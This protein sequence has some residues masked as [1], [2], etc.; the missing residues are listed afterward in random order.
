MPLKLRLVKLLLTHL[1]LSLQ[2]LLVED[3]EE[4]LAS[5]ED[6]LVDVLCPMARHVLVPDVN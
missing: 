2:D 4:V 6:V 3:L 1:V 5:I